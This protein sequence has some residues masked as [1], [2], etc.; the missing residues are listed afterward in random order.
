MNMRNTSEILTEQKAYYRA[1][2]TEYD[3]WWL[4]QGRFDQG[5]RLNA[6]WFAEAQ[7]V[8]AA[9]QAFQPAGRILEFACGTGNWTE[10]LLPYSTH[11]TA[12]D[13]APEMLAIN[14]RRLNSPVIHYVES[15]IFQWR[16]TGQYDL[17]FFG[18]WLSHV[19]PD[20]FADFWELVRAALAPGGRVFFVDSQAD[21]S[22]TAK[23]HRLPAGDATTMTRRLNDGREFEIFK[24]YYEPADLAARLKKLGWDFSVHA[25][26]RF[27]IH[28]SGRP[29]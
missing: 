7:A 3:E 15:D 24:L 11:I 6:M 28:G 21:L 16:P 4:R 14:A 19:P 26:E 5:P 20:R 8:H 9:L 10:R 2:A 12:V 22:S 1:R 13:N 27:F 17:V 29:A 25:T 23:D 18:F